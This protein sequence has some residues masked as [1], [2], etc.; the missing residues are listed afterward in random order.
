MP[1]PRFGYATNGYEASSLFFSLHIFIQVCTY[2]AKYCH[3][4]WISAGNSHDID[5]QIQQYSSCSNDVVEI[6]T[7]ELDKSAHVHEGRERER[8]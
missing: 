8:E 1:G 7:S 3:S 2:I 4:S 5:Y 6:G